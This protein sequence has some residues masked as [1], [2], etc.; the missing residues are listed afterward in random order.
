MIAPV[1]PYLSQ[2][3]EAGCDRLT[4]HPEAGPHLDRSLRAIRGLG[5]QAG[6]A[7]NP[8]TPLPA[9]EHVLDLVDL[10]L[11]MT[12]NP[13]FG[14]QSF[15]PAMLEKIARLKAMLAGRPVHIQVDG[16]ITAETAPRV[17]AAGADVLVAGSAVF[18]SGDYAAAI[19]TL[20]A[21]VVV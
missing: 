9:I 19:A 11:V 21:D 6:V 3:A 20:R 7:L 17:V 8:A 4:I 18:G 12:V 14:G 5:K 2:L 13:G 16:G 10:V 15:I 1:D